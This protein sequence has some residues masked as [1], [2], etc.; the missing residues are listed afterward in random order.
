M[1]VVINS[2]FRFYEK[3]LPVILPSIPENEH[4]IEV[5]I[6]GSPWEYKKEVKDGI[7]YHFVDYD[8]ASF[9]SFIF[10]KENPELVKD[11]YYYLYIHDTT[12]L[13]PL[14]FNKTRCCLEKII[15]KYA[16]KQDFEQKTDNIR[17]T[18]NGLSMDMGLY[19]FN[20]FLNKNNAELLPKK[21]MDLSEE[22]MKFVKKFGYDHEDVFLRET[23]ALG[24]EE[25]ITT[26]IPSP[27]GTNV[28]RI[29]EYFPGLDF[30]KYKSNW[31]YNSRVI[32]L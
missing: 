20:Y 12:K 22:S 3:S 5:I 32:H 13:G 4:N 15:I 29:Q 17:L 21:N 31:H 18:N 16:S 19:K 1:R 7:N 26:E 9:T 25:R 27:Y 6:G 24:S 10:I 8:N 28:R 30:Y 2:N 23:E 14:F 11:N